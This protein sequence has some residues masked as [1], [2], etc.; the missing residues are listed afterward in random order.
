MGK[1]NPKP[2]EEWLVLTKL[3]SKNEEV[4]CSEYQD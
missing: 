2:V 4:I 3:S 1:E